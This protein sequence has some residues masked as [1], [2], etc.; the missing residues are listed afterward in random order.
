[1]KAIAAFGTQ[2][3]ACIVLA[4]VGSAA[5]AQDLKS[6]PVT[7]FNWTSV[8]IGAHAGYG[9]ADLDWRSNYPF[10]NAANRP[11]NFDNGDAVGGAQVGYMIQRGNWVLG[12]ELSLTTGFDRDTK[13]DVDLWSGSAVGTMS[14]RVD[15]LVMMSTRIGYAWGNMLGY[16]KIGT[17]GA[18]VRLSTDDNVPGD[19]LST[20]KHFYTGWVFGAGVDYEIIPNLLLGVEYNFV[21]LDGKASTNIVTESGGLIGRYRSRVDLDS[22]S[23]LARLSYKMDTP[24]LATLLPF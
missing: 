3:V 17:A 4:L 22:H 1:M 19:F 13:R 24:A 6:P 20:S 16:V 11:T 8:Y 12:G 15:Y 14:A 21:T 2:F 23:V 7:V 18:S 5:K 9:S 10:G